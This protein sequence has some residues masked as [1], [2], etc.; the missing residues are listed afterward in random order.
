MG[1]WLHRLLEIDLAKGTAECEGCGRTVGLY[2]QSGR[3]P[4]CKV[5]RLADKELYRQRHPD[6]IKETG[7]AR[8]AR[9]IDRSNWTLKKET[10]EKRRAR[11]IKSLYGRTVEDIDGIRLAQDGKCAI[12][13]RERSLVIDHCHRSGVVRGLL[14]NPCNGAIGFLGDQYASLMV[15][16]EYLRPTAG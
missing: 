12:C 15:A 7:A 3:A 11:K 5:K 4:S 10:P 1:K 8:R 16:A 2:L 14:C 9:G 13:Q 6:K